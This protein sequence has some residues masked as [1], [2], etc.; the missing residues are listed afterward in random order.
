MRTMAANMLPAVLTIFIS[1]LIH[2]PALIV[3][4]QTS[5]G[6]A[7]FQ[8]DLT[9]RNEVALPQQKPLVSTEVIMVDDISKSDD[10]AI[11]MLSIS[12]GGRISHCSSSGS[13]YLTLPNANGLM[14]IVAQAPQ[15]G[16]LNATENEVT[17]R[18]A[19]HS[20]IANVFPTTAVLFANETMT[21]DSTEFR[22]Y[23]L[24]LLDLVSFPDNTALTYRVVI[25]NATSHRNVNGTV[26]S[27][28]IMDEIL[29]SSSQS[30]PTIMF[31]SGSLMID[32]IDADDETIDA[33]RRRY[34][35]ANMAKSGMLEYQANKLAA[36]PDGQIN[37]QGL[38]SLW[39]L[40]PLSI[41]LYPFFFACC[42]AS[43]LIWYTIQPF[44]FCCII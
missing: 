23:T 1:V 28:V 31:P 17:I 12:E 43:L 11:S 5:I 8:Q 10:S 41:P 32:L 2:A 13:S 14:H 29:P 42:S 18:Y 37:A 4:A 40:G 9:A 39:V 24:Q 44:V 3:E 30:A 21:T 20:S 27:A 6:G 22:L 36:S 38:L 26:A 7:G 19:S 35:L 15:L 25:K 16:K 34:T 33:D